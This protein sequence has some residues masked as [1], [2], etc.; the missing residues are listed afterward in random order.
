MAME[1]LADLEIACEEGDL[2]TAEF[3]LEQLEEHDD[4]DI[5]HCMFQEA[6][7]QG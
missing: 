5:G 2:E 4:L 3:I 6:F 1:L 7:P